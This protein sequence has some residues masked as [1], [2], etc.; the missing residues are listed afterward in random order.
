MDRMRVRRVGERMVAKPSRLPLGVLPGHQPRPPR[1]L[2]AASISPRRNAPPVS[3]TPCARIA[4]SAGSSPSASSARTSSSAPAAS[5]ASNRAAIACAQRLARRIE[6]HRARTRHGAGVARLAPAR[7]PARAR[8]AAPHLPRPRDPLAVASAAAAPPSPDRPRRAARA[9]PRGPIVRQQPAAPPPAPRRRDRR[10]VR[11]A[12][13]SAP[14]NRGPS[15]RTGSAPGRPPGRV[16]RRQRRAAPPRRAARLGRR[17]H[18]IQRVRHR[19]LVRRR[20]PRRQHAQLAIHLHRVGVDDGA[21]EPL[22]PE[23]SPAPTCRCRS[24]RRRSAPTGSR[25]PVIVRAQCTVLSL[26]A[27]SSSAAPRSRPA[28]SP[29]SATPSAGAPPDILSPGEAADIATAAP[30]DMHAVARRARRR[31]RRRVVQPSQ[32]D[33][34]KRLLLADMDSTIV[35]SRD[36]RRARRFAGLKDRIAAITRRSMNGELDFADRACASA[37]R[38]C[39]ASA[40]TRWKQTWAR[41]APDA[42]RRHAGRHHARARRDDGAGLRRLHLLHRP[43]R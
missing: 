22:A 18:A 7:P 19:R 1:R 30:P 15:R 9:A 26:I 31:P 29:P 11:D 8:S 2:L 37:S 27:A 25:R 34:R 39:E 21:A 3:G 32:P 13:A 10:D 28:C 43:G 33:R 36:A 24:A 42:R 14:R 23:P 17:P 35:T 5:I 41:T 4:G 38:C 20:R 12:V 40:W 16:H 6:Q